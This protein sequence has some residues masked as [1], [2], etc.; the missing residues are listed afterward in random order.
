MPVAA[1]PAADPGASPGAPA[2]SPADDPQL[3][4]KQ[5]EIAEQPYI[6][7]ARR[8][9]P[10]A[11][12]RFLAGLP[13]RA[14]FMVTTRLTDDQGHREQA[15]VTVR[16]IDGDGIIEGRISSEVHKVAGLNRTSTYALPEKD[17]IDWTIIN[18]D[19][20]EDGNALGAFLKE[21]EKTHPVH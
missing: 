6:D 16:R 10:E 8:T 3:R 13:Y 12:R 1:S 2:A 18:P 21:Y 14:T 15:F 7:R 9:Y 20:T 17:V 11:K 19:R 5:L 4:Q